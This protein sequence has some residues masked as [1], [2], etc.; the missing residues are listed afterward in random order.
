VSQPNSGTAATGQSPD[1]SA[2][3]GRALSTRKGHQTSHRRS[4]DRRSSDGALRGRVPWLP[5]KIGPWQVGPVYHF[6]ADDKIVV[7]AE[8]EVAGLLRNYDHAH[9]WQSVTG[10]GPEHRWRPSPPNQNR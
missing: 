7:V 8:R 2:Q 4:L 6:R 5:L 1:V 3:T 9:A 10:G